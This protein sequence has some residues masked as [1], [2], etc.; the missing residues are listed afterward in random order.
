MMRLARAGRRSRF[1]RAPRRLSG[2]DWREFGSATRHR[3]ELMIG[4]VAY[5]LR[6]GG[7]V[8]VDDIDFVLSAYREDGQWRVESL[9][10]YVGDDLDGL[11][12]T[13]R[14]LPADSGVTGFVSVDDD[15]FIVV[16]VMG[17]RE[18]LFLSDVTAA[19]DWLL[20]RQVVERLDLPLPEDDEPVQPAGD[21]SILADLG[22]EPMDLAAVCDDIDLYPD[23]MIL[24]L[25]S[26][27]GIGDQ[28]EQTLNAPT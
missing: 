10:R 17:P 4:G 2:S 5:A 26:M 1:L 7:P 3:R 14:R 18:R 20:A 8:A 12:S 23:E 21:A 6:R 11:T 24:V 25:A 27:M 22:V 13:L 19:T 28:A 15:F 16:R 9:P